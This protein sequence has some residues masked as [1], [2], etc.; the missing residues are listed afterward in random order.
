MSA[1]LQ[2]VDELRHLLTAT[3]RAFGSTDASRERLQM[4]S[5]FTEST[6]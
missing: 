1:P 3:S 6:F 4:E 2:N 5:I